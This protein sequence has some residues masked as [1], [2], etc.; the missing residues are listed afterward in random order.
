MLISEINLVNHTLSNLSGE[1]VVLKEHIEGFSDSR[2]GG[3]IMRELVLHHL[4]SVKLSQRNIHLSISGGARPVGTKLGQ[5]ALTVI[6]SPCNP[7]F[8]PILLANPMQPN[9]AAPY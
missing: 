5:M 6:F 4:M 2:D 3:N 1:R 8:S 9:F 7:A